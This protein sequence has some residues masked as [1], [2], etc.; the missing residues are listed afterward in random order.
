M[1]KNGRTPFLHDIDFS[2]K[3]NVDLHLPKQAMSHPLFAKLQSYLAK[4]AKKWW[5]NIVQNISYKDSETS[6]V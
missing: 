5:V 4:L 1:L 3:S 6:I 2:R